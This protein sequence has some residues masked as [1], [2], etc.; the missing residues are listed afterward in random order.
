MESEGMSRMRLWIIACFMVMP[1]G[2]ALAQAPRPA[3]PGR[4]SIGL[5][6]GDIRYHGGTREA[7]L[8][9]GVIRFTPYRPS[10]LGLRGEFGGVGLRIGIGI[11]YAEPGLAG[12][13]APE[14]GEPAS[15]T[16]VLERLLTTYTL[17]PSIS[18]GLARLKG[19]GVL[20][21]GF[22]LM[23]ERWELPGEPARNRVGVLGTL[24]LELALFGSWVG[25]LTGSYGVTPSS[26]LTSDDLPDRYEPA[27][28][29][30][31]GLTG[32]MAYRF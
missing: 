2:R 13:G 26:P 5:T 1:V 20:R 19:G 4:W 7:P 6:V 17:T 12:S 15:G 28:L 8:E 29:W 18:F 11:E 9:D 10:P 3:E 14:Q 16:I 25:S 31:R 32:A 21:P 23:L 27:A 22:G 24:T 30:R